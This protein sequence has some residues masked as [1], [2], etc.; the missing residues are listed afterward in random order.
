MSIPRLF[1]KIMVHSSYGILYNYLKT[2][3]WIC[4]YYHWNNIY[5]IQQ[6]KYI[7]IKCLD[8]HSVYFLENTHVLLLKFKK[9]QLYAYKKKKNCLSYCVELLV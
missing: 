4:M 2:M 7:H 3:K 1:T 9:K 8:F 5:N 6:N